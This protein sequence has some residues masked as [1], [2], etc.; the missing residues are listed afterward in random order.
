MAA[1]LVMSSPPS[2]LTRP[3]DLQAKGGHEKS[4]VPN[5]NGVVR[6]PDGQTFSGTF[7]DGLPHGRYAF[8]W[9][10]ICLSKKACIDSI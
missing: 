10:D 1:F 9:K 3:V 8:C 5:G 2:V 6:T 7:L 4:M